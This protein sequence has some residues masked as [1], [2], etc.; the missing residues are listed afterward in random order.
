MTLFEKKKF[1]SLFSGFLTFLEHK[2][3]FQRLESRLKIKNKNIF[4]VHLTF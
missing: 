1:S 3:P 2:S 4:D